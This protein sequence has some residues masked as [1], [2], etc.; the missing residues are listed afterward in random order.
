MQ[1]GASGGALNGC[2]PDSFTC[3][4]TTPVSM[5]NAC[6]ENQIPE[7][8]Q[9]A[10]TRGARTGVPDYN[11]G[12]EQEQINTQPGLPLRVNYCPSNPCITRQIH[13]IH[14]D[15]LDGV[16]GASINL[17]RYLP[18]CSML[19]A[20]DDPPVPSV[21]EGGAETPCTGDAHLVLDCTC[22]DPAHQVLMVKKRYMQQF[23]LGRASSFVQRRLPHRPVQQQGGA[24]CS[25]LHIPISSLIPPLQCAPQNGLLPDLG[26]CLQT[27]LMRRFLTDQAK[28]VWAKGAAGSQMLG[29]FVPQPGS[30]PVSS[31]ADAHSLQPT[32]P[33]AVP[34]P[35]PAIA[36][37]DDASKVWG[38][39]NLLCTALLQDSIPCLRKSKRSCFPSLQHGG[40]SGQA[41][42]GRSL[43]GSTPPA[44][45]G[46]V[47]GSVL[48]QQQQGHSYNHVDVSA[49]INIL[50]GTLLKLYPLGAKVPTFTSRRVLM[51]G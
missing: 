19:L 3:S 49:C 38:R 42:G 21:G 15:I 31:S 40:S 11:M 18:V 32:P 36:A 46:V 5:S 22:G 13:A 37:S 16:P 34:V 6:T 1:Q 29:G 7:H 47:D 28:K 8:P 48:Q 20:L 50:Y 41:A 26:S 2:C 27:I 4:K 10:P 14:K 30:R 51:P 17:N 43:E 33:T 12:C 23:K 9:R 45:K 39:M 35:T 44:K 25:K 24:S